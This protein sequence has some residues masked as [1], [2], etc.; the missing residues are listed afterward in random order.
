MMLIHLSGGI[1]VVGLTAIAGVAFFLGRPAGALDAIAAW[2]LGLLGLQV[3]SGMFLLTAGEEGP[4]L[5]HVGAPMFAL[6]VAGAARLIQP[7]SGGPDPVLGAAFSI[8][9]LGALVGLAT[10]LTAA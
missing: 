9:A 3:A 8:A 5:L 4:G 6:A 7:R 10:G 2:A 1:A